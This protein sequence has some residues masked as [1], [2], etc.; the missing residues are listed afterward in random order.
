MLSTIDG[1]QRI[2]LFKDYSHAPGC[3]LG[4][5]TVIFGENGVGKSTLA[6][7]LDAFRESSGEE[8]LRRRSLS[9]TALP[10]TAITFASKTYSFDGVTWN[11]Q[12]PFDTIDV[13]YPGFVTR[14]V[15]TAVQVEPEHKRNL[16]EHVL[17]R[18]AVENIAKLT[19]LDTT[20]RDALA[21]IKEIEK[22]IDRRLE[23]PEL[24]DSFAAIAQDPAIQDKIE[25]AERG[26]ARVQGKDAVL[27]RCIPAEVSQVDLDF[28]G[29]SS[30]LRTTFEKVDAEIAEIVQTHVLN[31]LD[32]KGEEWL[33]YGVSKANPAH[34]CPFCGQSLSVSK[35]ASSIFAYFSDECQRYIKSVVES[36]QSYKAKFG[37][38]TFLRVR[39]SFEIEIAKA[40]QWSHD[41]V[42]D[43]D[44]L[45][46]QLS[47]SEASWIAGQ[48]EL[49]ALLA[50][51]SATPMLPIDDSELQPS[52]S[53]FREAINEFRM[54]NATLLEAKLS[55]SE[56]VSA[57]EAASLESAATNLKK[58]K[59]RKVRFEPNVVELISER[60][61]LLEFRDKLP[62]CK[63]ILKEQIN[64]HSERVIGKYQ[65]S[66]N[67]YLRYLGCDLEI[68]D[69]AS[70]YP[71]G[72]PSVQYTLKAHGHEVGLGVSQSGPCFET[73][74]SESDK[75]SL[76]LSFFFARL[77][78]LTSL[79]GRTVVLDDP[80]YSLGNARR[81]VV[82]EIISE[83]RQRGAQVVVLTHDDILAA[84]LWR[85]KRLKV[86]PLK[87]ER[88]DLGS[89]LT[90]WDIEAE[91]RTEY[92][93]YYLT[94]QS[95]LSEGGDH[96][97]AAACIRLYLEQRLRHMYPGPP[98]R[99]RDTL[100]EMINK[101]RESESTCRL[102]GLKDKVSEFELLNKVSL[103]D[104]HAT[105]D[106]PGLDP[107]TPEGVR[108]FARKVLDIL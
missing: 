102:S 16:C 83:L 44:K 61:K 80:V 82:V 5:V 54:I 96:R 93:R 71:S 1:I 69:V 28:E 2:G 106:V 48:A 45:R 46:Q 55:A 68:A 62:G 21:R 92:V 39:S 17:G 98:F 49:D 76:A 11:A 32:K 101:I 56:I 100:T 108:V 20:G 105:D 66:I 63:S 107:L 8:I 47:N 35:L 74:L 65:D 37:Y 7:I 64:E 81:M 57:L 60:S 67:Y 22:Q 24:I 88:T 104:H 78:H 9:A 25:E 99:T 29:L 33:A 52:L 94:I 26:L 50:K 89:K 10:W 95:F 75:Y 13:F 91:T 70:R 97:P 77:K 27:R 84:A 42:C 36:S 73:L 85:N 53:H 86:V 72:K 23:T 38:A 19:Q 6:A 18:K 59:N 87:I 3:Q 43:C 51:K 14:N 90:Q 12:V 4:D 103:A 30:L 41:F 15:Y 34:D 79:A 58:L 40:A 31:A